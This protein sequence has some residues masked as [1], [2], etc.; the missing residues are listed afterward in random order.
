[1]SNGQ[2]S[3]GIKL[4]PLVLLGPASQNHG[5]GSTLP[6]AAAAD[7]ASCF[8][9]AGTP[10]QIYELGSLKRCCQAINERSC[11]K[12]ITLSRIIFFWGQ[13]TLSIVNCCINF[14]TELFAIIIVDLNQPHMDL[15]ASFLFQEIF[16]NIRGKK[17]QKITL[18]LGQNYMQHLHFFFEFSFLQQLVE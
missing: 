14:K 12:S 9:E 8:I 7:V 6:L 4:L 10:P 5:S 3:R 11:D 16:C 15:Y 13:E 2:R 1:M 17:K 18:C